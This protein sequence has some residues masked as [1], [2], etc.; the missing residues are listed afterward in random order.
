M[1]SWS[2]SF[3]VPMTTGH[4]ADVWK[5]AFGAINSLMDNAE[6][7][8]AV[9]TEVTDTHTMPCTTDRNRLESTS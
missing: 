1:A 8:V 5:R 7:G 2:C 6:M 3:Y 9:G 4:Q